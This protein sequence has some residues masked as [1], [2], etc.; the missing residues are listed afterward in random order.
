MPAKS[1]ILIIPLIATATVTVHAQEHA[2]ETLTIDTAMRLALERQPQVEAWQAQ[3]AAERSAAIAE[4]QLPDPKLMTGIRDFPIDGPAAGS[5]SQDDFTMLEVGV[6]QDVPLGDKRRLMGE[7]RV[8][9]AESAEAMA[10]QARREVRR[11]VGLAWLDAVLAERAAVLTQAQIT[12]AERFSQATEIGFRAGRSPQ[13]DV[14][15]ARVSA[16]LLADRAHGLR[17]KAR[18][19]RAALSRWIGDRAE[20][21]LPGE[22]PP[23][24]AAIDLADLLRHIETHPHVAALEREQA[25]AQAEVALAQQAYRPDWSVDAYYGNRPD[26]SDYVGLRFT[27]DLPVFT[28]QRQDRRLDESRARLLKAEAE[29]E[30]ARREQAAEARATLA[31]WEEIRARLARFDQHVLPAAR[32]APQAAQAAYGAG[33]GSLAGVLQA[34]QAALDAEL[35]RLELAVDAVRAQLRLQYYIE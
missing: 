12:E 1:L 8:H 30:N 21:P 18:E 4:Q 28:A 14:L 5:F 6:S 35:L 20:L 17:Q 3:A 29:R 31:G 27:I 7:R 33:Q 16:E 13:S 9:Q 32:S 11:D 23:A 22:L 24:T 15:S 2:A 19:A 26:F 34:R 25:A 10:E